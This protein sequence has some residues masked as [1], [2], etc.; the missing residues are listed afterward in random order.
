MALPLVLLI[1]MALTALGHGAL[2]LAL[3]QEAASRAS[4]ATSQA[5]LMAEAGIRAALRAYGDTLPTR[6]STLMEGSSADARF[7]VQARPLARE[8]FWLEGIGN[9]AL[10]PGGPQRVEDRVG[11]LAWSLSPTERLVQLRA[12]VEYGG[13]LDAAAGAI[14]TETAR[15][16]GFLVAPRGCLDR[17]PVLD[18]AMLGRVLPASARVQ[19]PFTEAVPPLG[20]LGLDSLL[21]RVP[22]RAQGIVTPSPSV[23]GGVCQTGELNWGSPGDPAG[24]CGGV[25]VALVATGDLYLAGGQGQGL[26]VVRGN[27]RLGAGVRFA[28]LVIVGGDLVLDGGATLE[29]VVRA[30]GSVQ[31]S[32]SSRVLASL[33]SA[34]LATEAA[35]ALRRP[36]ELPGAG[37]IR[38]L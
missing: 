2:L 31:L 18:T 7:R 8:V 24:P 10:S 12:A 35:P 4:G 11:R 28:G 20:Y 26:L 38:P 33:C 6:P 22:G 19:V 9:A 17:R 25:R 23:L 16:A 5:R 27:L 3:D 1:L 32:G 30:K 13:V 21:A 36:L 37:W 29:G 14:S 34:L 15:D